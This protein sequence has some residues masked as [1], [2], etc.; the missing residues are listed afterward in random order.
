VALDSS[1]SMQ[2]SSGRQKAAN[3]FVAALPPY[4]KVCLVDFSDAARVLTSPSI[5]AAWPSR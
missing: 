1:D 5:G 2:G 3:E 4:D